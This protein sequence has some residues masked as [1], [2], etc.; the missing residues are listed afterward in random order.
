[1]MRIFFYSCLFLFCLWVFQCSTGIDTSGGSEIGNPVVIIGK[2]M[3]SDSSMVTEALV[4][5]RPQSYLADTSGRIDTTNPWQ[6][7]DLHTDKEGNFTICG[8]DSGDYYIEVN[9][10]HGYAYL[11][12]LEIQADDSIITLPTNFLLKQSSL[13]GTINCQFSE[14]ANLFVRIIGLERIT[15]TDAEGN[16]SFFDLPSGSFRVSVPFS[17]IS[18]GPWELETGNLTPDQSITLDTIFLIP[19]DIN[20]KN[21]SLIVIAILNDLGNPISF[22]SAV[23][24]SD[25]VRSI[26]GINFNGLGMN[27]VPEE[28]FNLSSSVTTINLANNNLEN[29]NIPFGAWTNLIHFDVS[30]NRLTTLTQGISVLD[31]IEVVNY[32]HNQIEFIYTNIFEVSSLKQ[33]NFDY[34]RIRK[35]PGQ[36][37]HLVSL[38]SFTISH[39]ELTDLPSTIMN[40]TT[41]E[42]LDVYYNHL[43]HLSPQL[44]TWVKQFQPDYLQYQTYTR[45]H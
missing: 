43:L 14:E 7:Q 30:Y 8:I 42:N 28:I 44:D 22:D 41:L 29:F 40:I 35:I 13:T 21:D 26:I 19:N 31:N 24:I 23:D 4:R 6:V 9:D 11:Y 15:R 12:V 5:I 33:L 25:S 32:S 20:F 39:N 38:V 45:F 18:I 17:N 1:M 27:K 16:Y 34:N 36:I 10:S 2:V 37:G 3:Y